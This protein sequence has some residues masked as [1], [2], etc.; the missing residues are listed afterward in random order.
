MDAIVLPSI[1]KGSRVFTFILVALRMVLTLLPLT[2][3]ITLNRLSG[4]SN[5]S[6]DH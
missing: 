6:N 3:C 2:T 4:L 5:F 1:N